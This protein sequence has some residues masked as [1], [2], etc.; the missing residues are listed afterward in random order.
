MIASVL[1]APRGAFSLV[2]IVVVTALVFAG[3]LIVRAPRDHALIAKQVLRDACALHDVTH[4]QL[5]KLLGV[6][7]A[8]V[9]AALSDARENAVPMWWLLHPALPEA[10][11]AYVVSE[12]AARTDASVPTDPPEVLVQHALVRVG[13][14]VTAASATLTPGT[15]WRIG[16]DAAAQLLKQMSDAIVSLG[17]A[18]KRLQRRAITGAQPAAKGGAR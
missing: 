5:A 1:T 13:R 6:S 7:L 14:L 2:L 18:S 4:A 15:V 16:A 8:S 9:D 11:R 12:I 3:A 17:A 10:V